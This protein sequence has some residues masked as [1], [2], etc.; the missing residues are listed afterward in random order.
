MLSK[1]E[2]QENKIRLPGALPVESTNLKGTVDYPL[3]CSKSHVS[4]FKSR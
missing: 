4:S 2:E 1:K 3:I